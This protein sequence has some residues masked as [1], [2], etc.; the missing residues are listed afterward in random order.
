MTSVKHFGPPLWESLFHIAV[1]YDVN[2][3]PTQIKDRHY[4]IFFSSLG[5]VLGCKYCRI[6]YQKFFKQLNI[7]RYLGQKRGLLRFVYDLKNMVNEKLWK[8]EHEL[9]LKILKKSNIDKLPDS[10]KIKVLRQISHVFYTKSAPPFK[11]VVQKYESSI[12]KCNKQLK[13]CR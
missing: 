13:T 9:A 12:T 6:S 4:K 1:G 8:Q 3:E 11:D 7:E 10:E 2:T 5:H